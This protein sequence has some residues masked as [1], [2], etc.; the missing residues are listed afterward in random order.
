M[1]RD[2]TDSARGEN[3][4]RREKR[5]RRV[6]PVGFASLGFTCFLCEEE[7]RIDVNALLSVVTCAERQGVLGHLRDRVCVAWPATVGGS[8]GAVGHAPAHRR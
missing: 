8:R 5:L 4:E 7:G 1:G 2:C 3:L 6:G